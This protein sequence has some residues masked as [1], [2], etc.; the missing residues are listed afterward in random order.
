MPEATWPGSATQGRK[1]NFL[2]S[3]N[4]GDRDLVVNS[5]EVSN[6]IRYLSILTE[7]RSLLFTKAGAVKGDVYEVL[8]VPEYSSA[9]LIKDSQGD[10]ILALKPAHSARIHFDGDDW[11]VLSVSALFSSFSNPK[12]IRDYDDLRALDP[13]EEDVVVHVWEEPYPMRHYVSEIPTDPAQEDFGDDG[14]WILPAGWTS[15]EPAWRQAG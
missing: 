13:I 10:T 14:Q 9:L 3:H 8:L 2:L 7:Q 1:R 11:E 6:V 4:A 5:G 15:G 12:V